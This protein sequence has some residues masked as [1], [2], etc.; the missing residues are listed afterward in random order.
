MNKYKWLL[1][2]SVAIREMQVKTTLRFHL[3]Q[4]EWPSS[5]KQKTI[6]TGKNAGENE[7]LSTAGVNINY[8]SYCGN[9]YGSS[10]KN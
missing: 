5:R 7:P 8:C 3:T 2:T 6:N 9:Q 4:L 1:N 10:S